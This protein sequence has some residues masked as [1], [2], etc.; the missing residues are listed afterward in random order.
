MTSLIG[1]FEKRRFRN[2]LSYLAKYDEKDPSTFG[3]REEEKEDRK[4]GLRTAWAV[5]RLDSGGLGRVLRERARRREKE[6]ERESQKERE[7]ER[8]RATHGSTHT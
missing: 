1:L 6:R 5:S 4:R 2:F 7:R 8:E 3:G